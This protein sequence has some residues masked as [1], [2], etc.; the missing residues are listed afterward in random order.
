[1]DILAIPIGLILLAALVFYISR[2]LLQARR[3][4]KSDGADA[5]PLEAQRESL[6]TQ[7]KELDLDHATGKVNDQD[8]TRLRADLVAQAAAVLK[9]I[10]GVLRQPAPVAAPVAADDVES[11]IAA[12]RKTRSSMAATKV[13]ASKTTDGDIEAVIAARRKTPAPAASALTCPHCGKPIN[14]D[15][16][17]CAKCGTALRT[18]ATP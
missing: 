4:V 5:L 8:Y 17:F 7:I 15:D 14:A 1:M 12:R 3:A 18:Q 9:Q 2:P 13:A 16:A 10:D 11:L 6:Y